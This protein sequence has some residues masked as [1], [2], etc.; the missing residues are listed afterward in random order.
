MSDKAKKRI[1]VVSVGAAVNLFLFFIKL[2]IGL[3]SNSVAIY[4]DSLNSLIDS[5]VCLTVAVGF[6]VASSGS[7]AVYPFGKGR[8][9]ELT[10]LLISVVII[11]SGAAFAYTS[12]ER[13]LYPVPVWYST[14]YAVLIAVGAVIKLLLSA[15]FTVFSKKLGSETVK[16]IASDSRLDFF[17]TLCTLLSFT[18]SSKTE[19]SVDGAAGIIISTVLIIGG[20]KSFARSFG[21]NIGKRNNALCERTKELIE[22]KCPTVFVEEIQFHSYGERGVFTAK[23]KADCETAAQLEELTKKAKIIIKENTNSE[24]YF[25]YGGK[26]EK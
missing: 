24:I 23:V 12:F 25:E 5:I 11:A 7:N 2:Y 9:E 8:I 10:E 26:D 22:L 14:L 1:A 3:S 4:A 21:K 19:F 6:G 17:I 18:L 20:I 15:F 16:G 13:V